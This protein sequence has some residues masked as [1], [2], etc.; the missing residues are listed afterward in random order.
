M[1]MQA[2]AHGGIAETLAKSEH[3]HSQRSRGRLESL[4]NRDQAIITIS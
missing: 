1:T 3:N 2:T 4:G